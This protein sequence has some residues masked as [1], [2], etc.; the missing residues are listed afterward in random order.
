MNKRLTALL[1]LLLSSTAYTQTEAPAKDANCRV[2]HGADGGAPIAPSYPKIN[3]QNKD[4]LV[5]A[6]KAYRAGERKGGL[7]AIMGA[8][9][10]MLSDKDIEVLAGFY[11]LKK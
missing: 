2:C 4:Y 11:A 6:L 7:A 8:Q 1:M 5:S 9:A 3:G 10:A